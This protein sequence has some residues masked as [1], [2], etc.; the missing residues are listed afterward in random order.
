MHGVIAAG[1][2]LGFGWMS[3]DWF[4]GAL[5]GLASVLL[6]LD[7]GLEYWHARRRWVSIRDFLAFFNNYKEEKLFVLLHAYEWVAVGL[8]LSVAGIAPQLTLA[9]TLGLFTHL[10]C[11]Q[12]GNGVYPATYWLA[13]RMRR[14]FL[15]RHLLK[16]RFSNSEAGA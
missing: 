6:D 10:L 13:Y 3:G 4:A 5:A 2:T 1:L 14:G 9:V 15:T 8:L 16:G 12:I 7:H 11:D